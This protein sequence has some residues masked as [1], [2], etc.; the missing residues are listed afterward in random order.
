MTHLYYIDD[1]KMLATSAMNMQLMMMAVRT[2]STDMGL[3][4]GYSKCNVCVTKGGKLISEEDMPLGDDDVVQTLRKGQ[5]YKFLGLEERGGFDRAQIVKS[6]TFQET[7]RLS[8]IWS[9]SLSSTYMTRATNSYAI[10]KSNYAMWSLR[11]NVD[12]R[13]EMDVQLRRIMIRNGALHPQMATALLHLRRGA[14]GRG[15]KSH[16]LVY[17]ASRIQMAVHIATSRDPTIRLVA[18]HEDAKGHFSMFREAETFAEGGLDLTLSGKGAT[19][20]YRDDE[21]TLTIV[22]VQDPICVKRVVNELQQRELLRQVRELGW[23]GQFWKKFYEGKAKA[24]TFGWLTWNNMPKEVEV[25]MFELQAQLL[26]TRV[27]DAVR[28]LEVPNRQCRVCHKHEETI[29][30]LVSG[31]LVFHILLAE[32]QCCLKTV[33]LVVTETVWVG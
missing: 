14:G 33:V 16:E 30:H 9:S 29:P 17:Q 6:V 22:N 28:D 25:G 1:L 8:V 12:E 10:P 13:K 26:K 23:Q 21:D 7:Q 15:V 32:T 31:S 11:W 19:A 27:F 20:S 4:M 18:E 3:E 2:C 5:T 24:T